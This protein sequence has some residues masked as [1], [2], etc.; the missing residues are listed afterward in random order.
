MQAEGEMRLSDEV[1]GSI[2]ILAHLAFL[3]EDAV[4]LRQVV[5]AIAERSPQAE[6]LPVFRS[7]L[8]HL[9]K[10][11][12]AP[13]ARRCRLKS[14]PTTMQKRDCCGPG[15]MDL[16]LRYWQGSEK[17]TED[18]IETWVKLPH[19]GTPIYRMREFFHLAGF[20]TV[21]C[22]VPLHRSGR[23]PAHTPVPAPGPVGLA[24]AAPTARRPWG[25]N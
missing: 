9:E 10:R 4:M 15:T 18:E 7:M 20:D 2:F 21:R 6:R 24:A 5:D 17:F 12:A 23:F 11:Q 25:R 16:V 13:A 19:G 8:E 22:R 14:F 3:A 1:L